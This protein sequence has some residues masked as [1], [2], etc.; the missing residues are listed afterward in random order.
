[1][2][3]LQR[4]LTVQLKVKGGACS[5]LWLRLPSWPLRQTTLMD[6]DLKRLKFPPPPHSWAT[7]N[8]CVTHPLVACPPLNAKRGTVSMETT[9]GSIFFSLAWAESSLLSLFPTDEMHRKQ[10]GACDFMHSWACVS[11]QRVCEAARLYAWITEWSL[12]KSGISSR[13]CE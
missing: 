12:A 10:E 7:S 5:K 1:M 11:V 13:A 6:S 9:S 4:M 3:S 8:V 2:S